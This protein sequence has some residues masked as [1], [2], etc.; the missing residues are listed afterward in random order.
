M[1]LTNILDAGTFR[2]A[3]VIVLILIG[4]ASLSGAV[5]AI[6]AER[7]HGIADRGIERA[8]GCFR[9]GPRELH[10][11]EEDRAH[12]NGHTYLGR[13]PHRFTAGLESRAAL[14]NFVKPIKGAADRSLAL[15]SVRLSFVTRHVAHYMAHDVD[16]HKGAHQGDGANYVVTLSLWIRLQ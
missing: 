11:F 1:R 2:K 15:S 4:A 5:F 14:L 13:E 7:F 3:W 10:R 8:V 6:E 12:S 16:R 9:H